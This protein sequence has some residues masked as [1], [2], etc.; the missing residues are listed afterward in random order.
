[1]KIA[2]IYNYAQHYRTNI[3]TLL[4]QN[5]DIDFYFGD[6]YLDVKKMDYTLLRNRVT[7]V[8]NIYIGPFGW[9]TGII[10]LAL[11]KYNTF[12]MLGEPMVISSWIT[13]ILAR[14]MGKKVYFW[15]HGWYGRETTFKR[16]IK[17][18]F[19]GLANGCFL[20]GHYARNLMIQNGFSSQKLTV[21]HNSLMYD[22]QL[23]IRDSLSSSDIYSKHF[24]NNNPNLIFIGRLT[25]VKKL[26]QLIQATKICKDRGRNLNV[27]F[28]GDG[29]IKNDLY[30]LAQSMGLCENT[31]FYGPCYSE[32]ELS[33][34]L[35]NADICIAP[36][37]IG[38]TAVHAMVYG[39]PCISHNDFKWQMPEH[40]AIKEGITGAFF[41]KDNIDSLS[42][43][44][45]NWLD[46]TERHAVR[47]ACFKEVD[48]N[49]NPHIQLKI[50]QEVIYD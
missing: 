15:T 16:L 37:N 49:W 2:L 10:R 9:Q 1:M 17:K 39:C 50:M 3:F 46:T 5:W 27:I 33:R 8:K 7:E 25:P 31:W 23:K 24:H 36:G 14:L 35:F 28:V 26:H 22:E 29:V 21:I 20:Y 18:V 32:Q 44:I 11:K 47:M 34:L 6:K 13:L 19:F 30:E 42:N 4:D 41:Q 38:L 12:I 48:R 43:T 45:L 40:E